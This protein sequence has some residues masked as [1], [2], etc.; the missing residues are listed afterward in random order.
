MDVQ[1]CRKQLNCCQL[2]IQQEKLSTRASKC[3][4]DVFGMLLK[5]SRRNQAAKKRKGLKE[6]GYSRRHLGRKYKERGR[7]GEA[8][9]AFP[10]HDSTRSYPR[11]KNEKKYVYQLRI[12]FIDNKIVLKYSM[13][14]LVSSS[15]KSKSPDL[16]VAQDDESVMRELET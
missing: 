9:H 1:K 8:L 2:A 12:S 14:Q 11:R 4:R 15:A 3:T 7:D 10:S 13:T 16:G 5:C 6:V